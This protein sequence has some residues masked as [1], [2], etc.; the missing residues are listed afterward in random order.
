VRIK[1]RPAL[2][3]RDADG[4]VEGTADD[5]FLERS[6]EPGERFFEILA[7]LGR[8]EGCR[9]GL[10]ARREVRDDVVVADVKNSLLFYTPCYNATPRDFSR[11]TRHLP[12]LFF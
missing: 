5:R 1:A 6:T 12:K 8:R 2:L 3:E 11:L 10:T 7:M 9:I 4:F